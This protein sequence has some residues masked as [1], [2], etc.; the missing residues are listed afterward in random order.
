MPLARGCSWPSVASII[1][2]PEPFTSAIRGTNSIVTILM[3][4]LARLTREETKHV[5]QDRGLYCKHSTMKSRLDESMRTDTHMCTLKCT[6]RTV[7]TSELLHAC[8]AIHT[9]A[10]IP[11][12]TPTCDAYA[13]TLRFLRPQGCR[14]GAKTLGAGACRRAARSEFVK[15]FGLRQYL[16]LL[17]GS[18]G[19][20]TVVL[21]VVVPA[22]WP[23]VRVRPARKPH[24]PTT[25]TPTPE[26]RKK[27][28][29]TATWYKMEQKV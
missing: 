20:C 9:C 12:H 14:D 27:I 16:E 3:F 29:T 22:S 24:I 5:G 18:I 23:V 2:I 17:D 7:P 13:Y 8:L 28:G 21:V 4:Q 10:L 6:V 1:N 19:V 26:T 15:I 25:S 11:A